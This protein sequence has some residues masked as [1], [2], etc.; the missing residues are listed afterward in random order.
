MAC[1]CTLALAGGSAVFLLG[2]DEDT[3]EQEVQE[4]TKGHEK[5]KP[6]E[7]G[8]SQRA[9][10]IPFHA[11]G[12]W[13]QPYLRPSNFPHCCLCNAL[14]GL[15]LGS[16]GTVLPWGPQRKD[17]VGTGAAA[18]AVSPHSY[19]ASLLG[20]IHRDPGSNYL[21]DLIGIIILLA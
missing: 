17:G 18:A 19:S 3:K 2:E 14:L 4:A 1:V 12:T 20:E 10:S 13:W 11:M 21:C 7:P 9:R 8:E 5:R 16:T 6:A 15:P